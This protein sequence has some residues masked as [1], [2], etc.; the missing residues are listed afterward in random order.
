[1]C[2]IVEIE[3]R[4]I[5]PDFLPF[6]VLRQ[7]PSKLLGKPRIFHSFASVFQCWPFSQVVINKHGCAERVCLFFMCTCLC[8]CGC[9]HVYACCTLVCG[10]VSSAFLSCSPP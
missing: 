7:S 10:V 5:L 4:T 6:K 8:V 9:V 3:G 2:V 1:M